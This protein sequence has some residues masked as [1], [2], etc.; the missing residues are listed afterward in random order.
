MGEDEGG[1]GWKRWKKI[2]EEEDGR[3][4]R[5]WKRMKEKEDRTVWKRRRRGYMEQ[6]VEERVA[7]WNRKKKGKEA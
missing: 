4:G 1:G 7:G 5:G 6:D 2:K 3:D